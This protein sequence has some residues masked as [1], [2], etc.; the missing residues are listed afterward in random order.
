VVLATTLEAWFGEES[1]TKL[2]GVDA[3]KGVYWGWGLIFRPWLGNW[4]SWC[5]RLC[6]VQRIF[7]IKF[8]VL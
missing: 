3:F 5:V 1:C 2:Y 7:R 4:G 6:C 8:L